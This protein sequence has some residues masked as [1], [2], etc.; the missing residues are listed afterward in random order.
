MRVS[1]LKTGKTARIIA[2]TRNNT[3]YRKRLLAMGLIPVTIFTVSR[4]APLGDPI[5]IVLRGYALSLRKFEAN[6]LEIEEMT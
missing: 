2:I 1:D 6:I 3:P 4:M 5:E